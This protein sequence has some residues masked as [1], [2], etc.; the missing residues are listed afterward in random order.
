MGLRKVCGETF[1][2]AN[3]KFGAHGAVFGA[4]CAGHNLRHGRVFVNHHTESLA[5]ER[6]TRGQLRGMDARRV[7][8]RE[9]CWMRE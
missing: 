4:S 2:R 8:M 6:E 1:R 5:R 7:R 9:G 3:N